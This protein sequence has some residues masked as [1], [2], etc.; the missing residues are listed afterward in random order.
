MNGLN[1]V[2]ALGSVFDSVKYLTVNDGCKVAGVATTSNEVD[3]VVE[4]KICCGQ[5]YLLS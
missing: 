3:F 5:S 2:V 1:T 4:D